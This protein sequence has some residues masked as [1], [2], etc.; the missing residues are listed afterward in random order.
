MKG[1]LQKAI[2]TIMSK[3]ERD[4]PVYSFFTD[5]EPPTRKIIA[6]AVARTAPDAAVAASD[7][8]VT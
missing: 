2:E 7:P 1:Q 4:S 3:P 6:E 8:Y 5:L